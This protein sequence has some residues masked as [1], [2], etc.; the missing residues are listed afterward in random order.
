MLLRWVVDTG[1]LVEITTVQQLLDSHE[2]HVRLQ[3]RNCVAELM[4]EK[5]QNLVYGLSGENFTLQ[6][7]AKNLTRQVLLRELLR[8]TPSPTAVQGLPT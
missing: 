1:V 5:R 2:D 6:P 4:G 7:I 3:F 8:Y